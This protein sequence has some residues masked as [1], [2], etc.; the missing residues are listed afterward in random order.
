MTS[1]L[2]AS[3]ADL[4]VPVVSVRGT[5]GECGA[6]YGA[7]AA[8]L[9]ATNVDLYLRR[10]RDEAG[11][12]IDAVRT[13]GDG[14]R[15]ATAT[16]HPRVAQMLDGVAE[17][18]GVGVGEIYAL[19]ARTE[20]IYGAGPEG[21][22][23]GCTAVGVLGTHTASGHLLLGQNWDWHPDQRE[24]MVLLVT[25]DERGL[26]V[27]A[28]AEAGMLA[29]AGLNSAGV[30]VCVNMLGCDRDGL[31]SGGDA[32]GVPYHV[33][34]RAVLESDSLSWALRAA[35]R[36]PRNASINLLLGQADDTGG[37]LID[38]ELAPGEA[39]W[40]HPMDG[41]VTH[42]NHFETTLPVHDSAKDLGGSSLFRSA[43]A[44][45]LLGPAAAAGKVVEDD[46]AEVFR[47]HASF[48]LS[49][50]RHVDE[51][52]APRDRSETVYSVLLD[53]HERRFGLAAGPPCAHEYTWLD[54]RSALPE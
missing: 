45:R 3:P 36:S 42:A 49:I 31:P 17:G 5:P 13:A 2:G 54:L 9:I 40:L 8:G 4:P 29:K 1:T 35:C 23:G 25:H 41:L 30:G 20:L 21:A 18:A 16:H 6:A 46:V 44:R 26:A 34:L 15:R 19:N 50:C 38:L 39:G 22:D 47:D 24:A 7:A 28:L 48:P 37:E 11:L 14:F 53:L 10:F 51:R 27:L 33:L 12:T 32:P 43:R 52:D